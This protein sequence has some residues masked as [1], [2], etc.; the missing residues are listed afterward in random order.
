MLIRVSHRM[1]T[2][3]R[4]R[5]V[6]GR[7]KTTQRHKRSMVM[8]GSV[9]VLLAGVVFAQSFSLQAKN[10][11]Y[12]RKEA[13]LE[14]Q[15]KEQEERAEEIA[16]FEQ[17]VETEEYTKKIAKERLGLADPGEIVFQSQE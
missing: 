11:E 15:I 8:I 1:D 5:R 14:S 17:Y 16:E 13:E 3:K 6:N 4:N 9:I 10:E 2:K 12:Q 7:K